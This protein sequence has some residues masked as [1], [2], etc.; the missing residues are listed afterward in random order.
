VSDR[1]ITRAART[2]RDLGRRS[3]EFHAERDLHAIVRR[4]PPDMQLEV[5]GASVALAQDEIQVSQAVRRYDRDQGIEVGDTVILGRSREGGFVAKHVV[6]DKEGSK[7]PDAEPVAAAGRGFIAS[8]S[9]GA[10]ES[11]TA[12]PLVGVVPF[13][14]EDGVII[15]YIPLIA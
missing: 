4:P 13:R 6:S 9:L 3:A 14:D 12:T 1:H 10:G 7:G 5:I 8:A 11:V 2:L 15:G